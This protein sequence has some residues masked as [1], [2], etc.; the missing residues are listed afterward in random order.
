M[1]TIIHKCL[2]FTV[3]KM[4]LRDKYHRKSNFNTPKDED[5]HILIAAPGRL[6]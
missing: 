2:S 6:E 3:F 1:D 5:A 4:E